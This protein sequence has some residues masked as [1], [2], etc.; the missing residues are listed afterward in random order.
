M[1]TVVGIDCARH[2]RAWKCQGGSS[3]ACLQEAS[4]APVRCCIDS[5]DAE[6]RRPP[7]SSLSVRLA[8]LSHC[9]SGRSWEL[10]YAGSRITSGLGYFKAKG[11]E[12]MEGSRESKRGKCLSAYTVA[13][14]VFPFLISTQSVAIWCTFTPHCIV[15]QR[16]YKTQAMETSFNAHALLLQSQ[17][18]NFASSST[19]GRTALSPLMCCR[20][21]NPFPPSLVRAYSNATE[22]LCVH[23]V[24]GKW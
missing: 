13:E 5:T 23:C 16:T 19:Q 15:N 8:C 20:F 17:R 2:A 12:K 7:T 22:L 6:W 14:S 11:E 3:S 1:I 24:L 9:I 10:Q 18:G 21:S 4:S